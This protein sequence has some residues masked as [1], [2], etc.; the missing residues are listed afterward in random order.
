MDKKYLVIF[1]IFGLIILCKNKTKESFTSNESYNLTTEDKV[2]IKDFLEYNIND[3]QPGIIVSFTGVD[4]E[5]PI[6]WVLC[7]GTN[8]WIDKN[9][10]EQTTPDLKGRFLLG[11]GN[12]DNLTNRAVNTKGGEETIT[13]EA[14]NLPK[15][16]HSGT[17]DTDGAHNHK[18]HSPDGRNGAAGVHNNDKWFYSGKEATSTDNSGAHSH[19]FT[20]TDNDAH[21]KIAIDIMPPYYV[22]KYIIKSKI[23]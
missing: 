23:I 15:H 16:N 11:E 22:I 20:T 2:A 9:G 14:N 1:I 13:I 4:E 17:S 6:G 8:K 19:S 3:I 5:I 18:Y 21:E 7:N 10:A 12:G